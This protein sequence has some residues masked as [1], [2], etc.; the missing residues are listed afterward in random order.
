MAVV[1]QTDFPNLYHRG[2]IRDMYDL[3][4]GLLLMVSTD[5]ISAFDVVLPTASYGG[6]GDSRMLPSVGYQAGQRSVESGPM[7]ELWRVRQFKKYIGATRWKPIFMQGGGPS[8]QGP[9]ER[10]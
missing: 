8:A 7:P 4:G 2:K 6:T 9:R 10:D 1:Q 3:G 5:R